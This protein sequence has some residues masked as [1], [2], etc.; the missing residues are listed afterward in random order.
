LDLKV[1]EL[2]A[3][4]GGFHLGIKNHNVVWAN[5]MNEDVRIVYEREFNLSPDP[6]KIETIPASEIPI[7]DFL[8]GGFPCA[9]FSISGKRQG[10]S[11]DHEKGLLFYEIIRIAEHH[12]P[13][14]ILLENVEGLLNHDNGRTF[15]VV[16]YEL[17]RLGYDVQWQKFD[18][19]HFG[20][21]QH[22]ERVFILG[23]RGEGPKVFP[24]LP[25]S[26]TS[27]EGSV[28]Q[29]R[30][31]KVRRFR[32]GTFP[33]LTASMGTGGNNV[34]FIGKDGEFRKMTHE[35]GELLQGLPIGHTSGLSNASRYERIGRALNPNIVLAIMKKI[36]DYLEKN[37]GKI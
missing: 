23:V 14:F 19:V 18:S 31:G 16:L 3:G 33:C 1:V 10:L 6:R 4:I 24:I 21:P 25:E 37:D 15:A 8:C 5:D 7:H 30:R 9:T 11:S 22:R 28:Y 35:E 20:S 13:Q 32:R 17:G 36:D 26:K 29:F 34:P 27:F 12:L 2:F